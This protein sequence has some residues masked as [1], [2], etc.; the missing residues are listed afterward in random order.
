MPQLSLKEYASLIDLNNPYQPSFFYVNQSEKN[1]KELIESLLKENED[2]KDVEIPQEYKGKRSLLKAILN[3]REPNPFDSTFLQKLDSLLQTELKEKS[4]VEVE[5]LEMVSDLVLENPFNQSDK[6]IL[7]QGDITQLHADAIVNAANKYMLGCFQPLHACIDN[8][9][10]SAAGPQLREDCNTIMSTQEELEKTGGAKITR[11]YNLPA[12]FVL[13][14]VGP[15]VPKGTELTEKQREEL[16]SC[17][18][19]CLELANEIA[20]IKTI[21]FCAISTGVF[22]FPKPEAANIAVRTVNDWLNTHSHHFE[23]I[24]FNVFSDEDYKE[25]FKVFQI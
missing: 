11:G 15:I 8:V 2:L 9:I 6:F 12:K 17:Y 16:A 23:K 13:H 10:H 14:T 19:S 1:L 5:E 24:I 3:T 25:Y 18:V 22:G 20:E 21:A 7:W 4:V